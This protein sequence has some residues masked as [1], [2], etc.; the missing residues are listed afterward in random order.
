MI[1]DLTKFNIEQLKQLINKHELGKDT[2]SK[3]KLMKVIRDSDKW[4]T[5]EKEE[6]QAVRVVSE[7]QLAA[8]EKFKKMVQN[9][10]KKKVDVVE[11][12]VEVVE[13]K[14]EETVEEEN[15][16]QKLVEEIQRENDLLRKVVEV[17]IES[18]KKLRKNKQ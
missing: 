5:I 15:P 16:L 6:E 7:K 17:S 13:E 2:G 10:K 9:K 8:R 12:K 14:I 3:A 4:E 11:E 18:M 1:T